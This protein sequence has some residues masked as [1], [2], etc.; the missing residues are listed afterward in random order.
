DTARPDL[1]SEAPPTASSGDEVDVT[2]RSLL[3]FEL[4]PAGRGDA[5][6]SAAR[7][8]QEAA[9]EPAGPPAG[10]FHPRQ[11]ETAGE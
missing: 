3:L 9:R 8:L 10:A 5:L 1:D 7:A 11:E 6:Q 2:A 4:R